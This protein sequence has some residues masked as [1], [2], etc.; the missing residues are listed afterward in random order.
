MGL[1]AYAHRRHY[2]KQWKHE[3]PE[4]RY[5]VVIRRGGKPVPG[6]QEGRISSVDEELMVWRKAYHIHNWFVQNVRNGEFQNCDEFY[7]SEQD[8]CR[9][10]NTCLE[11]LKASKLVD[12]MVYAGT[13]YDKEHPEGIVEREPGRVIED[14]SVAK[15]LLPTNHGNFA[16]VAEYDE[17]YLSDVERTQEWIYQ[18]LAEAGDEPLGEIYYSANW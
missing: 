1:D 11:V 17:W 7:V 18:T 16:S 12:G 4:E 14:P 2:V 10:L 8:L 15:K 9:L 5:S 6:L 3:K 13:V